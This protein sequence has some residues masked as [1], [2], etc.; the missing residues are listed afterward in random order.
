MMRTF[1]LSSILA[2]LAYLGV[3]AVA[4]VG[5][6]LKFGGRREEAMDDHDALAASR[7]T[8]PVSLIVP[9]GGSPASAPIEALLGLNYPEF[10]V[11]VV[12][13][14]R[15]ADELGALRAEWDLTA[16]EFFYR[17]T[18]PTRDV[19]RIYRSSR[20]ARLL[21]VEKAMAGRADAVN[22]GVN[23]ARFRYV[24]V[25]EAGLRFEPDALLRA[26]SA[27]LKDPAHVVAACS[28]V[29]T[30][31]E[32]ESESAVGRINDSRQSRR[33][34]LQSIRSLMESRIAWPASNQ[35]VGP[36]RAAV[37]WRRDAL[38]QAAGFRIDAAD[39]DLDMMVRLQASSVASETGSR[40]VRT[41]EILGHAGPRSDRARLAAAAHRQ[42]AVIEALMA[43]GRGPR[44]ALAY[45]AASEVL[46]P[47]LQAWVVVGTV[48]GFVA[49][50]TSWRAVVFSVLLLSLGH[51]LVSAAALLLRGA[52]PD[53]PD[54]RTL[55]QLLLLTPSE[56]FVYGPSTGIA[57]LRGAWGALNG[58][59][60]R[61]T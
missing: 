22:C 27:P 53:A 33:Q 38:L 12:A 58:R 60:V 52:A 39:P 32:A 7:F 46:T 40:V 15:H 16:Q 61:S 20:D 25:V 57:R 19:H 56:L 4:A 55:K 37:V 30:R 47:L 6:A 17:Q 34:R 36:D 45:L 10:E 59:T 35:A 14:E 26:M 50:W 42:R 49:G 21:I 29:E 23:L 2:A 1:V 3:I 18:L 5:C 24:T 9:L 28:H 48:I 41:A 31:A 51:A 44:R 43:F 13:D 54:E 11:V 8:M